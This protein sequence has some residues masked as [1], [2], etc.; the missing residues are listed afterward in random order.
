MH[1]RPWWLMTA[2]SG[3]LMVVFGAFGAHVLANELT[4][5]AM[6][7][8][9]TGV[10]YQAWHT[11]AMLGVLAWR[12]AVPLP[13]QRLVLALWAGGM[14]LFCGSLYGLT[15][16]GQSWLGPITPLGGLLL[17]LGWLALAGVVLRARPGA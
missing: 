14:L 7:A 4:P 10:R 3:A 12:A 16:S 6:A 8:F 15:L 11:L 5:R 1:D 9:E 2:L 13:G 17:I